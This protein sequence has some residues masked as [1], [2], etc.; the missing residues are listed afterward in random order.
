MIVEP[1]DHESDGPVLEGDH[2]V[3]VEVTV[4]LDFLRVR[5]VRHDHTVRHMDEVQEVEKD[6]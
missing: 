2:Q 4:E 1:G 3:Q 5:E 6:Y